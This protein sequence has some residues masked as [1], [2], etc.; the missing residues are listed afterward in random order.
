M[1]SCGRQYW[2]PK[3][4][5]RRPKLTP[6]RLVCCAACFGMKQVV[7]DADRGDDCPD[8]ARALHQ[9]QDNQ[10]DCSRPEGV[11][12]HGPQGAEVGRDLIRVRACCPTAAE[13]G[14]M[15]SRTRRI[16][17]RERGQVRSR[18]TDSYTDLRGAPRARL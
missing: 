17:G 6:Y 4:G 1:V 8:P 10:G 5:D 3:P 18:A 9:G 12:E 16:A 14:T 13:A 7:R 2:P 15:G 11:A